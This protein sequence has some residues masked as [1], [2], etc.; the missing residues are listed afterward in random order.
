MLDCARADA[1]EGFPESEIELVYEKKKKRAS[2]V[3]R[4]E[5]IVDIDID[6]NID[7]D[8]DIYLMVWS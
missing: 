4:M 3:D 6:V 7:V 5:G 8:A 1:G 2:G